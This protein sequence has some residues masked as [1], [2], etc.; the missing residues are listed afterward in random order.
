MSPVFHP[1][2]SLQGPDASVEPWM[3]Q[4][5]PLLRGLSLIHLQSFSALVED[6][7]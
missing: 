3:T 6:V 1:P 7:L 5:D 2:A 4:D